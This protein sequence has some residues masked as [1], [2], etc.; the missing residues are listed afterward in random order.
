MGQITWPSVKHAIRAKQFFPNLDLSSP[1]R[2]RTRTW[3]PCCSVCIWSV[4]LDLHSLT[5]DVESKFAAIGNCAGRPKSVRSAVRNQTSQVVGV[6]S[7]AFQGLLGCKNRVKDSQCSPR[8][9]HIMHKQS[10]ACD[11]EDVLSLDFEVVDGLRCVLW[12]DA[13]H[14]GGTC[15][16]R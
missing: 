9:T 2:A 6:N 8:G 16:R 1:L 4:P 7:P 14:R 3:E 5:V 13:K 15:K 12:L 11:P 10:I